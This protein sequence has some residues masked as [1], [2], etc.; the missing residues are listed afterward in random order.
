MRHA[1]WQVRVPYYGALDQ[2]MVE[3]VFVEEPDGNVVG[4]VGPTSLMRRRRDQ[5]AG[6]L[7]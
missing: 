3:A 6:R 7:P 5:A 1:C 4:D 2:W